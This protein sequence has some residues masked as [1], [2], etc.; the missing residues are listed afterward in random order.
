MERSNAPR[1]AWRRRICILS[2]AALVAS[3]VPAV[4]Q[5]PAQAPI[6]LGATF[7]LTGP[8]AGVAKEWIPA[9]EMGVADINARGGIKGRP[10]Q[11]L[12]EDSR[13]TPEGGVAAYRKIVEVDKVSAVF[14]FMTNVVTAQIP[15]ADQLKVPFLSGTEAPGLA[16]KGQF[17]FS[18]ANRFNLAL[19][20]LM[21]HFKALGL[22]R[23]FVFLP[24]NAFGEIVSKAAQ[25]AVKSTGAEHSEARFKLGQS[26][27]RGVAARAKEFNA[28]AVM[29]ATQGTADDGNL[30]KQLRELG[31]SAPVFM[32][33]NMFGFKQW[34]DSVGSHAEGIILSGLNV[35]QSDPLAKE[36][37]TR[38][39]VKNGHTPSYFDASVYDMVMIFAA[40]IGQVGTDGVAI[41]D[42][43]VRLKDFPSAMGGRFAMAADRQ[44]VLPV[45]LW[46]VKG[47][48]LVKIN[49]GDR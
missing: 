28:D 43:I 39:Q 14:S 18:H 5:Q 2:G 36:F 22:K 40:A 38:Y 4:A 44:S 37:L 34:R 8:F 31:V 11:L 12:F 35:D 33:G 21:Q 23:V 29:I 10:V 48:Q 3:W 19:P 17:S 47:N 9:L 41:R 25:E 30:I 27:F 45:N 49:P 15:L 26:E 13:S 7:P 42:Y 32:T 46:R 6:K 20:P 16:A 1:R 24:D